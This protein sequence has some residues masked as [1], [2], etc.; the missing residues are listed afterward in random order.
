MRSPYSTYS[1]EPTLLHQFFPVRRKPILRP[2]PPASSNEI[3]ADDWACDLS[4]EASLVPLV[5]VVLG[6]FGLL[7]D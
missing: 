4:W 1:E 2:N 3:F 5:A 6:V 7:L